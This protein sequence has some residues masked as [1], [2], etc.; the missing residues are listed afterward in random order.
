MVDAARSLVG[1]DGA[2]SMSTPVMMH[3]EHGLAG[4]DELGGP[5][6]RVR[7]V[8]AMRAAA[9][10]FRIVRGRAAG[11]DRI[12][13]RP[14]WRDTQGEPLSAHLM[15]RLG[16]GQYRRAV[17]PAAPS[18]IEYGDG[19]TTAV[20]LWGSLSCR[21][22]MML[23]EP[24]AVFFDKVAAPYFAAVATWWQ[25]MRIGVAGGEVFDAVTSAFGSGAVQLGA[26]PRPPGVIR[27]VGALAHTAGQPRR[28][29]RRAWCSSPT[30]SRRRCRPASRST[31]RTPVPLR[32]PPCA[33]SCARRFPMCGRASTAGASSCAISWASR[34]PMRCL[35]LSTAP[36]YLPPFWLCADLV[37][38]VPM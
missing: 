12:T 20:S 37:C 31:A 21:A 6:R 35:P 19:V 3:P 23:G 22:G 2:L 1:S 5:D 18:D 4:G 9:A 30:S 13:R 38:A 10:V 7:V 36:A 26:E 11:H 8:G 32:T 25:T 33:R 24:D 17:Q 14:R 28:K 15:L 29:S 34:W 16:Q 27:R